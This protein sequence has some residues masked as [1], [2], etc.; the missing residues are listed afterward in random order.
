M[1][2]AQRAKYRLGDRAG[3][4][5][6]EGEDPRV[7]DVLGLSSV[8]CCQ[9]VHQVLHAFMVSIVE[10]VSELSQQLA[11]KKIKLNIM[12]NPSRQVCVKLN[13]VY[14]MF[15]QNQEVHLPFSLPRGKSAEWRARR[16]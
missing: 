9:V 15:D 8:F 16:Y 13:S 2:R 7:F 11:W 6:Q 14:L 12:K 5:L 10:I 4:G 3:L 1:H